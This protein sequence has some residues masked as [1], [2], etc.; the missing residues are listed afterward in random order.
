MLKWKCNVWYNSLFHCNL[1]TFPELHFCGGYNEKR[2]WCLIYF[3]CKYSEEDC[4]SRGELGWKHTPM[5]RDTT[6]LRLSHNT[7]TLAGCYVTR[8]DKCWS[9][10]LRLKVCVWS[11]TLRLKVCVNSPSKSVC[12]ITNSPSKSVCMITNSPSKSV[13]MSIVWVLVMFFSSQRNAG[14]LCKSAM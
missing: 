5:K 1:C 13:C 2:Q 8:G 3:F 14:L 10:T 7:S 4:S 12:M 11:Q 9:Q 6:W